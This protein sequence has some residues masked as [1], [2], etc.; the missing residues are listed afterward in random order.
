MS[1]E[2]AGRLHKIFPTEQKTDSFKAREFVIETD[3][4]YPQ[5][6]KFQLVQDKCEAMDSMQEGESIKVYFDLR[7]REWQ[8][9]YF[10]NLQAW[11]LEYGQ[12]SEAPTVHLEMETSFRLHLRK[13]TNL[14]IKKATMPLMTCLSNV[15]RI[16]N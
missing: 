15:D 3:G 16:L 6:V 10:T 13:K 8:G 11:K 4:Q 9:K 1:F 7:G 14:P 5:Y 2:I 12:S